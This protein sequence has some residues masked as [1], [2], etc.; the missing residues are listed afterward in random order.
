[1]RGLF[2]VRRRALLLGFGLLFLAGAAIHSSSTSTR[3]SVE[4]V[5]PRLPADGISLARVRLTADGARLRPE[6]LQLEI[7]EGNRRARLE[8]VSAIEGGLEALLR[9]G[10]L[11]GTVV[12]K[13]RAAGFDPVRVRLETQPD[14]SDSF[15]DGTPD[16]LRLSRAQ[17]RQAFRRWF[18]FLAESQYALP[19]ERRRSEIVD[20]AA[21]LRFAYREALA[22]H[23]GA[24]ASGLSLSAV[25]DA[26]SPEQ[27]HY[28][29]TP[30][31]AALFRIRLGSFGADEIS[32]GAF[33][34]FADAATLRLFNTHFVSRDV[35]RA[36]PGDLLFFRQLE[37]RMPSHAMIYLGPS[38]FTS[39]TQRWLLYHTGPMGKD[40]GELR[41]VTIGELA[42]HPNPRWRPV[43]GNLNFLG[44]YRWNILRGEG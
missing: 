36:E 2:P 42:R 32:G 41:R 10:V 37:Q 9:A 21:L 19:P 20:C 3:I 16:F 15:R 22:E 35:G 11:P 4:V 31:G 38:Q 6:T 1:M 44:V 5:P 40:P 34:Q 23:D 26:P 30:L 28:P 33:A 13:I 43:P 18:T 39:G 8:S 14:A 7:V 27:Y 24:W 12:I 29:F 17:D 25:P